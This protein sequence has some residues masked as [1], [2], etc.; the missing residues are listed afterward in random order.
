[1]IP[2]GLS[3]VRA[4][5]SRS[6][7]HTNQNDRIDEMDQFPATRC[8]RRSGFSTRKSKSTVRPDPKSGS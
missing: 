3:G 1:M 6:S 8:E 7:N 4:G 2:G 5:L